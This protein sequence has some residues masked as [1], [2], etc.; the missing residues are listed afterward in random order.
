[1][2][3]RRWRS[4]GEVFGKVGKSG[5][6]RVVPNK[7]ELSTKLSTAFSPRVAEIYPTIHRLYYY[8]NL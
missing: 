5:K 4:A 7:G 1:M 2:G 6:K 8:Y 3:I